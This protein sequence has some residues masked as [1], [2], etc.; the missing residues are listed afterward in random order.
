MVSSC[1]VLVMLQP[2]DHDP[3]E[4]LRHKFMIQSVMVQPGQNADT[5]VS[6]FGSRSACSSWVWMY[7]AVVVLHI[8]LWCLIHG[9]NDIVIFIQWTEAD[10]AVLMDCRLRV[11]FENESSSNRVSNSNHHSA[12]IF[13]L[14][15]LC[16][17]SHLI[18]SCFEITI[19]SIWTLGPMM[20]GLTFLFIFNKSLLFSK[21]ARI[22]IKKK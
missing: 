19:P 16:V 1:L 20:Q 18:G 3:N 4:R 2:F 7:Y 10:P 15:L 22:S 14:V 13:V 11:L 9:A 6:R 17:I 8:R 21:P 5:I 12:Q